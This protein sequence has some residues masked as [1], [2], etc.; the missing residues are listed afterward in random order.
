[1]S[2]QDKGKV[3]ILTSQIWLQMTVKIF[4]SIIQL[5]TARIIIYSTI[6]SDSNITY[7]D[8]FLSPYTDIICCECLFSRSKVV[9]TDC[10]TEHAQIGYKICAKKMF[11][12]GRNHENLYFGVLDHASSKSKPSTLSSA[13]IFYTGER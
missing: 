5:Q 10:S 3:A 9:V 4:W 6:L 12:S 7:L 8:L 11:T 1:M 13:M 2:Q